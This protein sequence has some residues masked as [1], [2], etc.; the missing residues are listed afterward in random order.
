M[1]SK[2][3]VHVHKEQIGVRWPV[4]DDVLDLGVQFV[5]ELI[6]LQPLPFV[7]G[8]TK[9]FGQLSLKLLLSQ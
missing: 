9:L 8:R 4:I 5:R 6:H 7:K 2:L 1:P 3:R